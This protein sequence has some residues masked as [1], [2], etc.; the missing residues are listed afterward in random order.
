MVLGFASN[1]QLALCLVLGK[2]RVDPFRTGLLSGVKSYTERAFLLSRGP[3]AFFTVSLHWV[4]VVLVTAKSLLSA[5]SSQ[6]AI[7]AS[8]A[9]RLDNSRPIVHRNANGS[10]H[11]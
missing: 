7:L 6:F 8:D 9:H 11:A 2:M 1:P 3:M 10:Q 5:V 4:M